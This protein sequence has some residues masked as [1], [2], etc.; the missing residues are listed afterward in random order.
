[1]TT[2]GDRVS[3]RHIRPFDRIRQASVTVRVRLNGG[4]VILL[5]IILA[6]IMFGTGTIAWKKA[7]RLHCRT[8]Q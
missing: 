2:P 7:D 6:Y 4:I 1:M 5:R 3:D 8:N